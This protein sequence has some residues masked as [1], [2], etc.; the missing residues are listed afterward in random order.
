MK[1]RVTIEVNEIIINEIRRILL[2]KL[3]TRIEDKLLAEFIGQVLQE[4]ANNMD[5]LVDEKN[6]NL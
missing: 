4:W 6:I 1:I 3:R 2:K 5:T